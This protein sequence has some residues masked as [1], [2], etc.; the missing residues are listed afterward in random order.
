M[1][2]SFIMIA[3]GCRK[4]SNDTRKVERMAKTLICE[5]KL[6]DELHR[7]YI[8]KYSLLIRSGES[9]KFYGVEIERMD[10][11]GVRER[12]ALQG[13][14]E[15]RKEAERFIS[16]L[17]RGNAFPTELAALYDDFVGEREGAEVHRA[18][19]PAC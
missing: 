12:D 9:G 7:E 3:M 8:L 16:R 11:R 6:R 15:K 4:K 14:S 10:A 19:R 5:K 2:L 17:W 18:V 13:V 1:V